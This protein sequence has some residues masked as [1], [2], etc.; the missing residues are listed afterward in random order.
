MKNNNFDIF[1][2]RGWLS[3]KN[4]IIPKK[5]KDKMTFVEIDDF[6][7]LMNR[8]EEILSEIKKPIKKGFIC[9]DCLSKYYKD[10]EKVECNNIKSCDHCKKW[11][12]FKDNIKFYKVGNK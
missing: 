6:N 12:G 8:L 3:L 4:H 9:Q 2:F 10:I 5:V 1:R 11:F 7:Y